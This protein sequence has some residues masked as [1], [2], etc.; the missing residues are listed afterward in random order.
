[1][2]RRAHLTLL[3]AFLVALTAASLNTMGILPRV[4]GSIVSVI[5]F[6]AFYLIGWYNGRSS[7]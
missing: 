2:S 1:M 6:A 5:G 3:I 4:V 7:R